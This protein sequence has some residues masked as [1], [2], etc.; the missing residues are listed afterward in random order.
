M[1]MTS[2]KSPKGINNIWQISREYGLLAGAGG[3]KDVVKQLAQALARDKRQVKV[4]MPLYGFMDPDKLGFSRL[5]SFKVELSYAQEERYEQVSIWQRREDITIYLVD[6]PRF[7]EKQDIYTYTAAEARKNPYRHKGGGHF[8]YF[9]M[10]VLHQKAALALMIRL[11]ERP[12]VIHCHDGHTALLP[13]MLRET[14]GYRH[15][16]SKTGCVVTIHNAGNGYHQE[17]AD[18]PFA[19]AITG[20]PK[21]VIKDNLLDEA[22]DPL[23]AAAP[24]ALLNTVSENY[25]RELQETDDDKLT[26]WLG[27][28]LVQRRFQLAGVTN[29]ID[30]AD[31]DLKQYKALGL[32]AGFIPGSTTAKSLAG[33]TACKQDLIASL[34]NGG[35]RGLKQTGHLDWQPELP[36]FTFV[37]RFTAQKGIDKL[38]SALKKLLLIQSNFQILILGSGQ[39]AEE[40]KLRL[41]AQHPT[42][43]GRICLLRGFDPIA[44]NRIFAAGDFFLIPS[45]FEPCGL[46]DF[47]AQLFGNLPIVHAVGG[48]V[49]VIDNKT[50]FT[51]AEHSSEALAATMQKAITLFETDKTALAKMRKAA[52]ALIRKKYTWDKVMD[53]YLELYEKSRN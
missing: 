20:L 21:R 7:R 52:L 50:G 4:V 26:G 2:P 13:A 27:H 41:L 39:K 19:E 15:Y 29:G 8:D 10:N 35:I 38:Q 28:T 9:A 40:D 43:R 45:Q 33:K 25:A 30:P 44:A 34:S 18:L 46:T 36:L 1:R 53:R 24:Y 48:L 37:G 6:S 22:F 47:Q 11:D 51:Y 31:Y 3:V 32:P 12:D 16:F 23:L 14:E 5:T 49:K 42:N 17:V